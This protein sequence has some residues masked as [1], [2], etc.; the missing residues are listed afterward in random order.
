MPR[1]LAAAGI[2][3][4]LLSHRRHYPAGMIPLDL[5]V[6]LTPAIIALILWALE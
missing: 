4:H 5:L 1:R 2:L 3:A 6:A